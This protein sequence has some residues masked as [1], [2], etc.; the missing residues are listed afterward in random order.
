MLEGE[1]AKL[2]H[3]EDRLRQRVIGQD[4]AV[5]HVSNAVRRSRAGLA[6]PRRPVGSFIFLGPTGVGKTELARAVA[7]FLFD[8]ERAMVRLDMSEYMEKHSV[9]RMIGAP[10]G[11][12]GYEEGGQ[13]TEH[14]RR[15]PFSVILFDEIEKAHP[16]VFNALLQIL[17]DGRLTDG[18][19]RTVDFKNAILIMTSNVGSAYLQ[20]IGAIGYHPVEERNGKVHQL[21]HRLD[22][23]LRQTF[24]PEFLNRIDDIIY[25]NPLGE[26]EIAQIIELQL[27]QLKKMLEEKKIRIE[28]QPAAKQLLFRRGYDPNFGARPLRRAIQTMI[29]D[30]LALKLL[31]GEI[32]PGDTVTVD[33]DLD[34]GV[35]TFEKEPVAAPAAPS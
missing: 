33:A 27:A 21:R 29:Q 2:V 8:D 26:G 35:M 31:D 11:Y 10:P 17:D 14:V 7:E 12:V 4:E 18:K 19:G 5:G 9:A 24:K 25:F 1:I 15:R 13:L 34:K 20:Q 32:Q 28:L 23:A 3:M 30:P 6:D 16:D 22:E